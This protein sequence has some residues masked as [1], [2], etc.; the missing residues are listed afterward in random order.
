MSADYAA[1]RTAYDEFD[2]VRKPMGVEGDSVYQAL[3]NAKDVTITHD[4][5]TLQLLRL[6]PPAPNSKTSWE[7]RV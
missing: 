4:F 1:W 7:G 2:A 6:S 3:D 5:A